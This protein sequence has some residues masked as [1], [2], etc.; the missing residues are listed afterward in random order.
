MNKW[1]RFWFYYAKYLSYLICGMYLAIKALHW[2]VGGANGSLDVLVY[3]AGVYTAI[4]PLISRAAASAFGAGVV[5]ATHACG[6]L[7]T[8]GTDDWPSHNWSSYSE[9]PMINPSTGAPMMGGGMG[10]FD[11]TGHTWGN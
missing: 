1:M 5:A 9:L 7:D 10:G 4:G 2:M 3:I 8:S 11:V 6:S